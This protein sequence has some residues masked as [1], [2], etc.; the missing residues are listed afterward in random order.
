MNMLVATHNGSF[1]SDDLFATAA[2]SILNNGNITNTNYTL[3][4]SQQGTSN[5][6]YPRYTFTSSAGGPTVIFES[7]LSTAT[8]TPVSKIVSPETSI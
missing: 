7:Q 1:H 2:L 5:E 3:T 4:I 6:Y 8:P